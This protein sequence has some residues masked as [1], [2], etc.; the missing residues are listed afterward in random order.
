MLGGQDANVGEFPHAAAL[1][2]YEQNGP[3]FRCGGTLISEKYK[4]R[5]ERY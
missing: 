2:V 5:Y 1:G 4:E 3:K